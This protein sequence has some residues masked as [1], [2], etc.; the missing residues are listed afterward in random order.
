[1]RAYLLSAFVTNSSQLMLDA[2]SLS[3]YQNQIELLLLQSQRHTLLDLK[4]SKA[5][6]MRK[7]LVSRRYPKNKPSQHLHA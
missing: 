1:M 3:I 5:K 2:A 4:N 7:D 6:Y